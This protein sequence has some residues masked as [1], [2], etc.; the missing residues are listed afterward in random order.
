MNTFCPSFYERIIIFLGTLYS[1][2]FE[3]EIF[4]ILNHWTIK[5]II[6]GKTAVYSI[7]LTILIMGT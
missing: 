6:R 2:V 3:D 5:I 7:Y 4:M 1:C